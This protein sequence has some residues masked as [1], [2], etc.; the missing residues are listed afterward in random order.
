MSGY[1]W[2]GFTLALAAANAFIA[3]RGDFVVWAWFASVGLI[4]AKLAA[5]ALQGAAFRVAARRNIA[6]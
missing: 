2:A 6:A 4:A 3:W 5:F 1:V